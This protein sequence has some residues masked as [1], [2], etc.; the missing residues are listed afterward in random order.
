MKRFFKVFFIILLVLFV[1][2]LA[3][4][5]VF[6]SQLMEL[7]KTEINKNVKATVDWADFKVSLLRGFPDLKVSLDEMTVLGIGA[8]EGD[9]LVAFDNFSVKVDLISAI[10]GEISIKSIILDKPVIR[11]IAL[12][13]GSVNWDI[14]YPSEQVE[15]EEASPDTASMDMKINLREFLINNAQISY[16]D[17]KGGMFADIR[18]LDFSLSGNFSESF[19]DLD[20][21]TSIQALSVETGGVKY[22]NEAS[23]GFKALLFADMDNMK[24]E[25][26]ENEL[27]LNDLVLGLEGVFSIPNETDY[28]VDVRF[29]TRETAFKTLLSMVPAVYRSDFAGLETSGSLEINGTA[30]GRIN[31]AVNP[32]VNLNLIVK[33][34]F[35]SYPDL[36]ESVEDIHV[37]L[38][39]FYDGEIEDNSTVNLENFSLKVAGNP[40]EARFF[41]RTPITD[42]QMNGSLNASVDLS[43]LKD[44]IPVEDMELTGMVKANLEMMGKMSDIENENYEAFKA[45]G[46]L[47]IREVRL[48]GENLPMPV[49]LE[50]TT[51][52][53]SPQYVNLETF[54][55][56]F[57]ESDIQ[58][59]GRLENFIPY[60]FEDETISGEL[61]LTSGLLDLNEFLSGESEVVEEEV[62]T[63]TSALEVVKIPENIDFKFQASLEKVLYDKLELDDLKGLIWARDGILRMDML[64]MD[65]LSGSMTV[66]GEYDSRDINS[67][68]VDLDLGINNI[69]IQSAFYTFNTVERL[70]PLAE[71]ADGRVSVQMEYTSFLDS[72]MMPVLESIVGSGALQTKSVRL[73]R[74][75]SFTKIAGLLNKPEL[76][77][78]PLEDINAYFEIREGKVLVK[79]F[80][81]RLGATKITIGGSQNLDQTMD[82]NL[83]FE[84]PR[85]YMGNAAN[86]LIEDLANQAAAKGFSIEPGEDINVAIKV[87]GSFN[88]PDISLD[89]KQN[90]TNTKQQVKE[91]VKE[92]V[93]E[94]I[95]EVKEEVRENVDEKV[96]EI[97]AEARKQA[98]R[99]KEE[100]GK[101]GE[102]LI[103]EARLRKAQL[104]KEAGSNPLKKVAAEKTGDALIKTAENKAK[105]LEEE[106]DKQADNIME[107][108]EKRADEI[109]NK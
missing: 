35:F 49:F 80:N 93:Q 82:Y 71:M 23:L 16:Y 64:S 38:K 77:K 73:E 45:D 92:K 13:D 88:D 48:A 84:I 33:Q 86:D 27:D 56:R 8:F 9:T 25:I 78:E 21:L 41:V 81:T 83:D 6:K 43:T 106:A 98:E 44:A 54:L 62:S 75:E 65:L 100:A 94:E 85:E 18:D 66:N 74:S 10:S 7:A 59:Q 70:V 57:G 42:M 76:A 20:L 60:I 95:E 96:N 4:P 103:G 55:A 30:K 46:M 28:E 47:E 102:D 68:L 51:L 5:L 36:P 32:D 67:P 37:D 69:D 17:M 15:E 63:D 61:I 104:V 99:V 11:A 22:L 72:T 109:K 108:A 89:V 3:I 90:L 12:E 53:F 39:V 105:Q 2:V 101:A 87:Q 52:L 58:L 14:A 19:T 50:K 91:A 79:P 29:F 31:E 1:T 40:V 24:F 34:G 26:R 107:E 97:M